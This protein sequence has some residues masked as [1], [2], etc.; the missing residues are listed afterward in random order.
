MAPEARSEKDSDDVP[1]PEWV[2]PDVRVSVPGNDGSLELATGVV[3]R[4]ISITPL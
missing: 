1:L 3:T 4:R 2:A